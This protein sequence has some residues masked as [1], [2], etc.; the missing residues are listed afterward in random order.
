MGQGEQEV[1]EAG[2]VLEDLEPLNQAAQQSPVFKLQAM[3]RYQIV[4]SV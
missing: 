4:K 1:S 2:D 3:T